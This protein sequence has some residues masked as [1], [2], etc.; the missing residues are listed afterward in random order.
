MAL[1]WLV[2]VRGVQMTWCEYKALRAEEA[3]RNHRRLNRLKEAIQML[4]KAKGKTEDK[5]A[6]SPNPSKPQEEK[7]EENG[8]GS[9]SPIASKPQEKEVEKSDVAP[10]PTATTVSETDKE[11]TAEPKKEHEHHLEHEDGELHEFN[12][13]AHLMELEAEEEEEHVH[14]QEKEEEPQKEEAGSSVAV[15]GDKPTPKAP[16]P[17]STGT[18]DAGAK[19]GKILLNL[20]NNKEERPPQQAGAVLL[21]LLKG[22]GTRKVES[23][24]PDAGAGLALLQQVKAGS[25]GAPP[26]NDAWAYDGDSRWWSWDEWGHGKAGK[27]GKTGW[28]GDWWGYGQ[29]WEDWHERWVPTPQGSQRRARQKQVRLRWQHYN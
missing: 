18:N 1:N 9:E 6:E 3:A 17:T 23:G 15:H 12:E 11:T 13:T 5:G 7:T 24:R 2:E 22:G 27:K 4:E 8:E 16:V 19:A 28:N 26:K 10:S 25:L 21:Q 20:V 29:D 14:S